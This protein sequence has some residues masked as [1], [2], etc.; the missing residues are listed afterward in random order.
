MSEAMADQ[1]SGERRF[2]T[3]EMV[4]ELLAERR[5]MLVLYCK[6]SGRKPFGHEKPILDELREFCEVLV[7]YTALT[8]FEIY[9]RIVEGKERRRNVIEVAEE[10]HPRIV[11]LT[12]QIVAF[13]DKYDESDHRLRLDHLEGDLDQLGEI[14]AERIELED[15]IV[16]ALQA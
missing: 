9:E 8:H 14:I 5:E 16:Q 11:E 13:N 12:T 6:V 4:E 3:K 15:R 10:V 1:S 7:D 2:G